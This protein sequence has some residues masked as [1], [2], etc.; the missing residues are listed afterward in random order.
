MSV[1]CKQEGQRRTPLSDC[2]AQVVDSVCRWAV[3][4]IL[5]GRLQKEQVHVTGQVVGEDAVGG[6]RL[7]DGG[8]T[9][10][11]VA[12]HRLTAAGQSETAGCPAHTDLGRL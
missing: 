8:G 12:P 10:E 2:S 5:R 3:E 7:P 9:I 6:E 1:V 11:S 4:R